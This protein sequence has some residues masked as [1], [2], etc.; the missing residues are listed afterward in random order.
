MS[1]IDQLKHTIPITDALE[2]YAG[3]KIPPSIAHRKQINIL[4]PF[5]NDRRPSLTIY[6]KSNRF[7]CHAGCNNRR[8]GSVIDVVLLSRNVSLNEAIN[9]LKADYELKEPDSEQLKEWQIKRI[10]RE[11]SVTFTARFNKKAFEYILLLKWF[12]ELLHDAFK[13]VKN[14]ED[15]ERL[16]ELYHLYSKI[17][18]WLDL[19]IDGDPIIQFQT[20]KAVNRFIEMLSKELDVKLQ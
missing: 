16:S 4:C 12:K 15:M 2:R 14:L 8:P 11:Q 7:Y 19:L 17:D 1:V 13:L 10:E 5:H 9:I 6:I 18:Y 3:V 20:I